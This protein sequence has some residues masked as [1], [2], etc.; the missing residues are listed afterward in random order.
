MC[1]LEDA[2]ARIDENDREIGRGCARDHVARVLNVSRRIGDDELTLRRREIA[3]SHIDGD[4]LLAL[5]TQ[6]IREQREI[7][8]AVSTAASRSA[9]SMASS[10]SSKIDLE[11]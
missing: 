8:L 5:G 2:F 7:D 10:W 11:S 1:L 4:A 6:A 9:R 3:I